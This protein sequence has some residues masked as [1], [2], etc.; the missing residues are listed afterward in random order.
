MKAKVREYD[1]EDIRSDIDDLLHILKQQDDLQLVSKMKVMVP[2]F[3]S[4]NSVF[5]QLDQ[6]NGV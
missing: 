4:N 3:V 2:E 6:K 1:F 5:E